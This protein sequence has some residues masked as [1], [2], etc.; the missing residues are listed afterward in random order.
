MSLLPNY[1]ALNNNVDFFLKAGDAIV[2][3]SV[4][5]PAGDALTLK[6]GDHT[7]LL[8]GTAP[9]TAAAGAICY[10]TIT[11]GGGNLEFLAADGPGAGN[12]D[13]YPGLASGHT[14]VS[15]D[16]K[17]RVSDVGIETPFINNAIIGA[18]GWSNLQ[19]G[20]IPT[21]SVTG[22]GFAFAT[23][24]SIGTSNI[25][26]APGGVYSLSGGV[27]FNN[28][29]GGNY[30]LTAALNNGANDSIIQVLSADASHTNV[31]PIANTY[32]TFN[33]TFIPV[34]SNVQLYLDVPSG[35]PGD[36]SSVSFSPLY[37]TRI[38]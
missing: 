6:G 30:T 25:P 17:L 38:R 23:I 34:G 18:Q 15:G 24:P 2:V 37:L 29:L 31:G 12:I 11:P 33:T 35:A 27:A 8:I 5:A 32:L 36:E 26:V 10:N 1:T 22:S 13:F 7:E 19:P 14:P 28:N 20:A 9:L 16:R 21:A 3:Q 4:E